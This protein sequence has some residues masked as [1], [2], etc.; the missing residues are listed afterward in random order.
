MKP[1]PLLLALGAFLTALPAAQARLNVVATLPD[2][3]ALV[4]EIGGDHVKVTSLAVGTEDPHFV[5]PKPSYVRVLN[6]ADVLIEGGA[7]LE[8]GWLPPLVHNARNPKVVVGAPSRIV[9]SQG[10]RLLEV[11]VGGVDRA[12]GDVHPLGN[13]HYLLAPDNCKTVAGHITEVFSQLDPTNAAAFQANLKRF[14]ERLAQKLPEWHKALASFRGTP[15]LTYHKSFDYLLDHFG[16][17]LVGTIEPKPGIE[18]S[19]AHINALVPRAKGAGVKL[20]IIEPNRPRRTAQRVADAIGARLLVL[21]L[22]PGGQE[23][24]ADFFAWYDYNVT[25]IAAALKP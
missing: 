1:L 3:A 8:V 6:Q 23:K 19:P 14:N 11:P 12:Q 4:R 17:T 16:F 13:P 5:D 9:A 2:L 7:E 25:Q 15:V 10:V 18:P 21:P 24:T 20:V 22:M